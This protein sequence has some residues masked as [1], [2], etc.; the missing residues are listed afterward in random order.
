MSKKRARTYARNRTA[1]SRRGNWKFDEPDGVYILKLV[2]MLIVS[3]FWLKLSTPLQLGIVLNGLP[4]GIVVG[5]L[6][7]K[8]I[9][10]NPVNRR[11]WFV[12]I[13]MVG[14]I[15]YFLPAGI[16]I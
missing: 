9:E 14:I 6:L 11:I 1:L 10:K 8:V 12:V 16:V 5:L 15:S 3:S 7:A 2:T 13:V 4:I